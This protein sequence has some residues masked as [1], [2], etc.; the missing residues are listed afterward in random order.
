MIQAIIFDC[1][2]TLTD[3]MP[4]H[5]AG[6]RDALAE[7]GMALT[8]ETFFAHCGTPSRILIPRLAAEV[9]VE[10]DYLRALDAKETYFLQTISQL[11]AIE[12]IVKIARDNRGRLPMAVA[13]GGTRRLV[14]LQ[15]QQIKIIDWFDC[16]VTSEDTEKGKPDPDIFLEA[17]RRLNVD[18]A[19][20]QVYEDGE[21]GIEAA[22]RAGMPCIDI[23]ALL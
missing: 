3:S 21:P 23:R 1:D 13:S 20:C 12:P 11:Q 16:I 6:W 8:Q 7:Q 15:L 4:G 10:V 5:Y 22:R 18:P 9:G 2:G 14:E 17:A 19:A